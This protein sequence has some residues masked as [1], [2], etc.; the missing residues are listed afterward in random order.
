MGCVHNEGV[1]KTAFCRAWLVPNIYKDT[2]CT[3]LSDCN[4]PN[5]SLTLGS[6]AIFFDS[7]Y[8]EIDLIKSL[9]FLI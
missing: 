1:E 4:F 6:W 2:L 7:K 9:I 8:L 3:L 5:P